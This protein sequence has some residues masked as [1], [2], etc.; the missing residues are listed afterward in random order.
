MKRIFRLSEG[1][2]G[3][4]RDVNDEIRLHLELRAKE[5]EEQGMSPEDARHA[6]SAAFGDVGAIEDEVRALHAQTT[7]RR[8]RRDWR[9]GFLMDIRFALRTLHKNPASPR[10]RSRR[11]HWASA[12]PRRFLPW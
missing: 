3:A 7:R 8:V 1:R 5:F 11:S 4:K 2:A 9:R 10:R 6:A 12:Q